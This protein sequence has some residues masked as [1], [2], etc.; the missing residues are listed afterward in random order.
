MAFAHHFA[1]VTAELEARLERTT[2]GLGRDISRTPRSTVI[3]GVFGK[4]G[5]RLVRGGAPS[6]ARFGPI[7]TGATGFHSSYPPG[8]NVRH[9]LQVWVRLPNHLCL[10]RTRA[11]NPEPGMVRERELE[12]DG[13]GLVARKAAVRRRWTS[14]RTR[15][16]S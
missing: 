14:G 1:D 9:K 8:P 5:L 4:F 13:N 12:L 7:S 2:F 11:W 15:R 10:G 3:P 16:R 6:M